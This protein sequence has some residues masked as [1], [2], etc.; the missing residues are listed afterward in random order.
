M[1]RSR[2]PAYQPHSVE[3][4]QGR[5]RDEINSLT[6]RDTLYQY[7]NRWARFHL[8]AHLWLGDLSNRIIVIHQPHPLAFSL[9]S[10]PLGR[11]FQ[12]HFFVCWPFLVVERRP[13]SL[14]RV[15]AFQ[16]ITVL[17]H[18]WMNLPLHYPIPC[19]PHH[20][21]HIFD[22]VKQV[23]SL[24]RIPVLDKVFLLLLHRLQLPQLLMIFWTSS[25]NQPLEFMEMT[26]RR[27]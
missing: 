8:L 14:I 17:F 15:A 16:I 21:H 18:Q 7:F 3:A 2:N 4:T 13:T 12:V 25:S 22:W 26:E 24:N 27:V 10:L 9:C 5:N 11:G 6:K 1:I 19:L 23:Q 20:D